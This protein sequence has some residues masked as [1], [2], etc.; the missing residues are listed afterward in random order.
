M[1]IAA[2]HRLSPLASPLEAFVTEF[3]TRYLEVFSGFRDNVP[4]YMRLKVLLLI[5]YAGAFVGCLSTASIRRD[6]N[7]LALI[8]FGIASALILTY[9]DGFR[10][11]IYLI[12]VM[13]VYA[14]VLAIW[15][16]HLIGKQGPWKT[17]GLAGV[18]LICA[19]T[20][21]TV[22]YRVGV[23]DYGQLYSPTLD[24]LAANVR[25]NDLVMGPAE[26]GNRLGFRRHCLADSRLG[27]RNGLQPSYVVLDRVMLDRMSKDEEALHHTNEV[28]G[29][30]DLVFQR[31]HGANF[32]RVYRVRPKGTG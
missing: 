19:Y 10:W 23:N 1:S 16:R 24:F 11:Y 32:Y 3:Q 26:F 6:R 22:A 31:E 17:L 13:P 4:V 7:K 28:L 8:V 18:A 2:K 27:F 21:A 5:A 30:S 25:G 14:V 20:F 9:V 15:V 12:H 29:R